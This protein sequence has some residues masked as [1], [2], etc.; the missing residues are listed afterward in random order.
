MQVAHNLRRCEEIDI[1]FADRAREF[2]ER[3]QIE[4]VGKLLDTRVSQEA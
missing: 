3:L 1:I 2:S 4:K